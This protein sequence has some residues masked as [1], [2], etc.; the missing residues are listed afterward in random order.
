MDDAA[1][2]LSAFE[3]G[4]AFAP[5]DQQ[6]LGELAGGAVGSPEVGDGAASRFDGFEQDGTEFGGKQLCRL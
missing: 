4:F 5:V 3:A 2:R 1:D 6:A